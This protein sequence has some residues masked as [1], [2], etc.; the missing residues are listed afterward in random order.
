MARAWGV[1]AALGGCLF[2]LYTQTPQRF[3]LQGQNS[4]VCSAPSSLLT[5]LQCDHPGGA[6]PPLRQD[7]QD[8]SRFFWEEESV[9]EELRGPRRD[10]EGGADGQ[11]IDPRSPA[12]RNFLLRTNW[13]RQQRN[14]CFGACQPCPRILQGGK[15]ILVSL[16]ED[17]SPFL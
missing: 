11:R 12:G 17:C 14:L 3:P 16:G 8:L 1:T 15:V 9:A 2:P 5:D 7:F 13:H 10:R 6:V 4:W